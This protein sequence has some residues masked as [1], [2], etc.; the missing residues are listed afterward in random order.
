MSRIFSIT[1]R[2][3]KRISSRVVPSGSTSAPAIVLSARRALVPDTNR[4]S[5][6]RF[7]CGYLPRGAAFPSTTLLSIPLIINDFARTQRSQPNAD[8]VELGVEIQ[9]MHPAFAANAGKSRATKGRS[10]IP[11]KP[12][13]HPR[14]AYLHLLRH[15]MTTLQVAGPDR[16]RQPVLCVIGQGDGFLF[17]I[18]WRNVANRPKDFFLHAP[19]RFRQSSIDGGF[20]VEAVVAIVA[21]PR[22]SSARYQGRPFFLSQMVVGEHLLSVLCRNQRPQVG[23]FVVRPARMQALRFLL[24]RFQESAEKLPLHINPLSAQADL[25]RIKEH[26]L[27]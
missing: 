10:Q 7:T 4:K 24:Q 9:G 22:N 14:D 16:R 25:P 21:K 1:V 3:C 19:R 23:L 2:V 12:A 5:P 18:K 20:D 27:R 6:A 11:Q 17:R 13:I 26:R 8:I 15:T